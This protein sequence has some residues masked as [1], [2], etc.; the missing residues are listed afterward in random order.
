MQ[1]KKWKNH[2][3]VRNA[4]CRMRSIYQDKNPIF[5]LVFILSCFSSIIFIKQIFFYTDNILLYGQITFW[6][7]MT[8]FFS[9]LAESIASDQSSNLTS[10]KMDNSAALV[11]KLN[12]LADIQ[13]YKEVK[14]GSIKSGDLILLHSGDEVPFDGEVTSG[15]SYV[16][17]TDTTGALEYKLKTPTKDSILV[18]GSVI[19]GNDWIIM[20]VSFASSKSFFTRAGKLL[21]NI[22][23]QA[24]PS[25][26]AL[27]KLILGLSILFITVIFVI[28]VIS[29]YSG[30]PI[31]IIYLISLM[32]IL[33]P[34]TI[35]GLQKAIIYNGRA[36]IAAYDIIVQDQVAFDNAVNIDTV[37]LDKTG[38]LTIGQRE[39][40]EFK[41]I[42]TTKKKDYFKYLYLSSM[43]DNTQEGKTIISFVTQNFQSLDKRVKSELYEHLPFSA[44]NPISGCNYDNIE[45]RKGSL[46]AIAKYLDRTIESMP[47]I[48]QIFV[49]EIAKTH[50][51]PLLLTVDKEIVGVINLRD[52]LRE[53][54]VE[55]IHNI[56]DAGITTM[57][58]TGDNSITA[59]YIA[60]KLGIKSFYADST[61]EKKLELI[62]SLQEKGFVVAMCGD[63]VNDALALAQADIGYTFEDQG[64][65]HSILSGNIIAKHYDLSGLLN[66][67]NECKKITVRRGA[68]TVYSITSDLAKYFVIVPA[69]FTTAF[70]ALS[71]LNI[72][73][74]HSLENALLA[75]VIFNALIIPCLT[76]LIFYDL[77]IKQNKA[78]LWRII[79]LCGFA[80]ITSP[81][82]FIKL[83]ELIIDKIGLI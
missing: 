34:T 78:Y 53:G 63:G 82:L 75:S 12:S 37:L 16:N 44:F 35:S 10:E 14:R 68:L 54:I 41:L 47:E 51:T 76:P 22:N 77:K 74:F 66:L 72:M 43:K 27:Q 15:I 71:K 67:K 50:G 13:T 28:W 64:R 46:G 30:S 36:K 26:I 19:E 81:F 7:W 11:K 29:D 20:K 17:E 32:V 18:A 56:Q 52:E 9:I 5:F 38:T 48:V 61:P 57:M 40:I 79:L 73:Q 65:V 49:D 69:L 24:M 31:P 58:V 23:R 39:M 59:S 70:P 45:I 21:R 33:L 6:L 83:I 62:R 42:S 80:G 4:F 1:T 2:S 55:Q 3:I 25:E 8:M 60:E